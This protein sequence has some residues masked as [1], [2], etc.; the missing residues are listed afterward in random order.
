[1]NSNLIKLA[2][3][4]KNFNKN[5]SNKK[6]RL[7]SLN[8]VYDSKFLYFNFF[9]ANKVFLDSP[10]RN[11]LINTFKKSERLT[12]G[13][14]Y[15][16]ADQLSKKILGNYKKVDKDK[17]ERNIE[18]IFN[19]LESL[20][21]DVSYKIFKEILE[22]SGP[23]ATITCQSTKNNEILI[24]KN[25]M[26]SFDIK[27]HEEFIPVYFNNVKK[28]TKNAIVSVI[29][30][31]I[32]RESELIPL[33]DKSKEEKL[34]VLMIC[35]GISEEAVRNL[36]NILVRNKIIFYPYISKFN[37]KDP[38]LFED[39]AKTCNTKVISAE[40]LDSIYKDTVTYSSESKITLTSSKIS[41]FNTS[42]EIIDDVNK[43]I[44]S[45]KES[46]NS[47]VI[48][49]LLK[50][51]KRVMPNNVTVSFPMKSI[52]IMNEIK[53][54]IKCYNIS[55]IGGVEKNGE[56]IESVYNKSNIN[57][58]SESLYKNISNLGYTLKLGD[59]SEQ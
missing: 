1:M 53:S 4:L 25:C 32:E 2:L 33:I 44:K 59:K 8:N 28:T 39:I 10:Y 26:P 9:L 58:L 5:Y 37:D 17:T 27:I 16:I 19:Y 50:R 20:T 45:A 24:E 56:K 23:D 48:E 6:H 40:T 41:F 35:R 55:A 47:S 57:R 11:L 14:S 46:N 38:F 49:Y 13:S 54:L 29:D 30:G 12:P 36:K 22:F 31:F 34:P 3:D 15:D 21:D 51:K 42:Q 52:R 18:V 43:H 7:V